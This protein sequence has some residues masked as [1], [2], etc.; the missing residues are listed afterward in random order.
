MKVF[1][2]SGLPGAGKTYLRKTNKVLKDLP[3]LDIKDYYH[4]HDTWSSAMTYLLNDVGNMLENHDRIVIE[5]L[6]L[7]GSASR[8]W[9]EWESNRLG[10]EVE[11][12]E[13]DTSPRICRERIL[14]G[15]PNEIDIRLKILDNYLS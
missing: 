5:A 7:K 2:L 6:F 13:I 9:L 8:K 12:I 3:F 10:F 14:H 11:Y 1:A 4:V 15:D